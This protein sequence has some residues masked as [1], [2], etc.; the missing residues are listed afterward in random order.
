MMTIEAPPLWAFSEW[1]RQADPHAAHH[2]A[3]LD[4]ARRVLDGVETVSA[5]DRVQLAA[6]LERWRYHHLNEVQAGAAPEDAS[7]ADA[8]DLAANTLAGRAARAPRRARAALR[9]ESLDTPGMREARAALDPA[10]PLERLAERAREITSRHFR[11][12]AAPD[13]SEGAGRRMLLYVPLYLSSLCANHCVYCGFRYPE[14]IERKHLTPEQAL[15]EAAALS[16]RGFRHVLLVAGD[17][18][19]RTTTAYFAGIL[20]LLTARGFQPAIEIAPQTTDA[21]AELC[22]AGARGVTLYQET[23]DEALYAVYHPRG[24]KAS[25]DWRIEGIERAAEAGMERLGLGI[26][27]GL[28]NP[29]RDFVALLR[30]ARYLQTRFP[31][32]TLAFSLPRIHEAPAGFRPPYPVDDDTLVRLYGALR[33]AFPR[34][35]LVLS[36]REPAELRSRLARTCITQMSAGSSTSPGGYEE[37]GSSP[38][39]RFGEQFPVADRRT[40]AEVAEWLRAQG[41]EIAWDLGLAAV[42]Q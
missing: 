36:T 37:N 6:R 30:H 18:P 19:S 22:A 1:I 13:G 7:L 2:L 26:L 21:Y 38:K 14:Q 34:A 24:T 41:F 39:G 3:L 32:R 42:P 12:A 5:E 40:P 17:F 8:L 9:D 11:A 15:R 29:R 10:F 27:L 16:K 31:D 25:Y 35:E 28:G 23:Y 33:I 20:R 4:Q